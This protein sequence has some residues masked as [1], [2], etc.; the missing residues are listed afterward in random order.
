MIRRTAVIG[1]FSFEPLA[2]EHPVAAVATLF[3]P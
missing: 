1:R 2:G 3:L